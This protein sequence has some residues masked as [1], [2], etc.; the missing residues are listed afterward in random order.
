VK[1]VFKGDRQQD[2]VDSPILFVAVRGHWTYA[3][4]GFLFGVMCK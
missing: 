4:R 2:V 1:D 3:T